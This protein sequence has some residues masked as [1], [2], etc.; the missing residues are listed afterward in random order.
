M[1]DIYC[2]GATKVTLGAEGREVMIVGYF[3]GYNL[4]AN[5]RSSDNLRVF[6]MSPDTLRMWGISPNTLRLWGM[7]PVTLR[8]WGTSP[9][10][11]L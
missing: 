7:S 4:F 8:L 1:I 3:I 10:T 5:H 6:A 9:N 2:Y 11:L